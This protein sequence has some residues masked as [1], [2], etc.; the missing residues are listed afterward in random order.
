MQWFWFDNI[1][2]THTLHFPYR[3]SLEPNHVQW[4]SWY[5][6]HVC[7][8]SVTIKVVDLIQSRAHLQ[9][10]FFPEDSDLMN[11]WFTGI[12]EIWAGHWKGKDY[13]KVGDS[14][15]TL[16]VFCFVG[17]LFHSCLS[18]LAQ[19]PLHDGWKSLNP[20]ADQVCLSVF[21]LS[22]PFFLSFSCLH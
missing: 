22:L 15:H 2:C 4:F 18:I 6:L 1:T 7:V 8:P 3:I 17:A 12:C 5:G 21:L 13:F 14:D 19:L 20:W 9:R 10:G 11:S 16:R